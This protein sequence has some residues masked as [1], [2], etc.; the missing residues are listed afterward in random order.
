MQSREH[1]K[2]RRKH[3]YPP[4]ASKLAL[5]C[6]FSSVRCFAAGLDFLEKGL[7]NELLRDELYLQLMKMGTGNKNP[8]V[9][10]VWQLMLLA[11]KTFP[12]SDS[13]YPYLQL[14][15]W[16]K[17]KKVTMAEGEMVKKTAAS[18]LEELEAIKND[19]ETAHPELR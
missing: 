6:V 10:L 11:T 9:Q 1:S 13:L 15:I 2:S 17:S 8:S 5:V 4:S 3:C 19:G 14:F 12:P 7:E 18:C 16:Q